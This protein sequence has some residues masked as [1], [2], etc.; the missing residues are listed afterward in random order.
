MTSPGWEGRINMTTQHKIVIAGAGG[1]GRAVALLLREWGDSPT[2]IW[3]GDAREEA[4]QESARW[5]R[6]LSEISDEVHPFTIP[7][8]GTEGDFVGYLQGADILLDCLPGSQAPRMALLAKRHDLHYAN[9]TEHVAETQEVVALARDASRG[10]L[11]QTGLAPGVI[12]VLAHGL[13]LSFCRDYQVDQ[14]DSLLMRVGA[15]PRY[16]LP[17]HYYGFTWSPIGVATEYVKDTVTLR[18]FKKTSLPSL[19]QI[20]TVRLRGWEL[21]EGLTSGGAADLPDALEGR[22]RELDYKTLRYPGHYKWVREQVEHILHREDVAESLES[23]MQKSIPTVEEDRVVVFAAAE[24]LDPHE[25]RRR[26]EAC[27]FIEATEVGGRRLKAIQVSTAAGLAESA[28][29][30]LQGKHRGV[31]LQSHI[32]PEPFLNGPF[33]SRVYC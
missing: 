9:L 5:I 18:G 26:K 33:V 28:R 16:A 14:V 7:S 2:E 17:P 20:R 1:I 25:R 27:Y 6:E 31:V 29:L 12:D 32:D 4:A 11:L 22:V 10:F 19:T 23:L 8:E 3:I 21:E 15:L 24:G 30:L 13:F